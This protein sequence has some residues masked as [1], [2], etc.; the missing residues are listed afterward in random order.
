MD[1]LAVIGIAL[2]AAFL[3]IILK[4]TRPEFALLASLAAGIAILLLICTSLMP[5][6]DIISQ[7]M[8]ETGLSY[9]YG[10]IIFKALSICII[11]QLASDTCKD[12]G[13]NAIGSKVELAGRVAILIISLPL[14]TQVIEIVKSILD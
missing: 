6:V 5:V 7:M 4:Q 12:A 2:I 11:T 10:Q 8:E 14:F 3:S 1:I 9:E 13:E